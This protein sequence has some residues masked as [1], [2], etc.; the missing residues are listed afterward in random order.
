MSTDAAS[1]VKRCR[2]S[3]VRPCDMKHRRGRSDDASS[4]RTALVALAVAG[5]GAFAGCSDPPAIPQDSSSPGRERESPAPAVVRVEPSARAA[6]WLPRRAEAWQEDTT[7]LHAPTIRVLDHDGG[8]PRGAWWAEMPHL[9]A[10]N[11]LL[12]KRTPI[13]VA[14]GMVTLPP[15]RDPRCVVIGAPE[16]PATVLS[17]LEDRWRFGPWDQPE[18]WNK[19]DGVIEIRLRPGGTTLPIRTL[20]AR[21]P[22]P[23]S[24][25]ASRASALPEALVA[26]WPSD[27][28]WVASGMT[29]ADGMAELVV[30]AAPRVWDAAHPAF[31]Y[32]MEL[33]PAD[34][35]PVEMELTPLPRIVGFARSEE[36]VPIEGAV[37]RV[38][39][40]E[41][42]GWRVGPTRTART[43]ATGRFELYAARDSADAAE[44]HELLL[45]A[46][47]PGFRSDH[48]WHRLPAPRFGVG[49]H[50]RVDFVLLQCGDP[51]DVTVL[52]EAGSP[53]ACARVIAASGPW[54]A[55]E[56]PWETDAAGHVR[57]DRDLPGTDG[58]PYVFAQA[59]DGRCGVAPIDGDTRTCVVRLTG[60]LTETVALGLPDG[61]LPESRSAPGIPRAADD[62]VVWAPEPFGSAMWT[63]A[64]ATD[65]GPVPQSH[66]P[67]EWRFRVARGPARI[68]ILPTFRE[69]RLDDGYAVASSPGELDT[70]FHASVLDIGRDPVLRPAW[71]AGDSARQ[72]V[73]PVTDYVALS[74][75]DPSLTVEFQGR[76]AYR[77]SVTGMVP[78][79]L[80]RG[81]ERVRVT[82]FGPDGSS[83]PHVVPVHPSRPVPLSV[84]E[85]PPGEWRVLR[86]PRTDGAGERVIRIYRDGLPVTGYLP[87]DG[88]GEFRVHESVITG[89][90]TR[91]VV[92]R[93]DSDVTAGAAFDVS[94]A[95]SVSVPVLRPVATGSIDVRVIGP[96]GDALAGVEVGL[97]DLRSLD[98]VFLDTGFVADPDTGASLGRA[99]TDALGSVLIDRVP[100]GPWRVAA[101]TRDGGHRHLA[102][103]ATVRCHPQ[104]TVRCVVRIGR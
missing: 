68:A 39:D 74:T 95:A 27:A 17:F 38:S 31:G 33:F 62:L 5:V 44:V 45:V 28:T 60:A 41:R 47:A 70:R 55:P 71:G 67:L 91:V 84:P 29:G 46:E 89:G 32:D 81:N 51:I 82:L 80:L 77:T 30:P 12:A 3:D 56:V 75:S 25:T 36:G 73:R 76:F 66:D 26:A 92:H 8:G 2:G 22:D 101:W 100:D 23:S 52:D 48:A 59:A 19:L 9:S 93:W 88:H 85:K 53:V 34:R 35:P 86:V 40:L 64:A 96:D 98:E 87:D 94:L 102:G 15:A 58:I 13:P 11:L 4:R 61:Y 99:Y 49:R 83:G 90:E 54:G 78:L 1:I 21:Q 50:L 7:P 72:Q 10:S 103:M 37:V 20:E 42:D 24:G 97:I 16:Y 69:R 6:M 65:V 57:I 43:D 63:V 79:G 14:D 18:S 104:A